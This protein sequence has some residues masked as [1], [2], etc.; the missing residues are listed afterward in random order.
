MFFL[1]GALFPLNTAPEPIRWLSYID[2]MTYVVEAL[3][4]LLTG[5]STMAIEMSCGVLGFF[6]VLSL[7]LA[8]WLFNRIE[9]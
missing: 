1:S 7:V 9:S 3:R 6:L 2:P 8:T 5:A 4:Y